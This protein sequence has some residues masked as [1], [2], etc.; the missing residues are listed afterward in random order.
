[1]IAAE[2]IKRLEKDF[3]KN[4]SESWDN[5]GI[6]VGDKNKEVKKIQISLDAT[7]KAIDNAI[8][9]S[10]D[11]MIVH[12]PM[13]FSSIKVIDNS[14]LLGRKIIKLIKN[15][16]T[17]YVLHTNIDSAPEGLNEY[18][19]ELLGLNEGK[20]LDE[21]TEELYSLKILAEGNQELERAII[22]S[23]A[24]DIVMFQEKKIE[25]V[26]TKVKLY[27]ILSEIKRSVKTDF[28]Y[29]IT[30]LEN[31]TVQGGIGRI[32]KLE[33]EVEA[34]KFLNKIKE[35]LKLQNLRVAGNVEKKIKKIGIVNGAGASYWK[36]VKRLGV[37]LFI[38]GD[39]KY[40]EA[41]DANEEGL[42]IADIGHDESEKFFS[43]L[44]L[45]KLSNFPNIEI[46]IYEEGPLFKNY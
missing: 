18:L 42:L 17:L 39:V 22:N 38:T 16:I 11:L 7:E 26:L 35:D 43:T 32:Y 31:K 41:L 19:G 40:H 34:G 44:I 21:K 13:I 6:L 46:E 23:V 3:P 14:D 33:K 12:H 45:K 24:G 25:I 29:L 10:V 28:D 5:I 27:N 2:I 8:A 1:M 30:K 36:K 15:D 37:D 9:D 4:L 20:V